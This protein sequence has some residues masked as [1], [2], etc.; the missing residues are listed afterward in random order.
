MAEGAGATQVKVPDSVI[1]EFKAMK[2]RRRLVFKCPMRVQG[3]PVAQC[4]SV[5]IQVSGLIVES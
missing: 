4:I 2:T 1:T 5:Q 3:S